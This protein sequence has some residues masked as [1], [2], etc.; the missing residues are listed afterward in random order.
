M[1][2]M[3]LLALSCVVPC[4]AMAQT[5]LFYVNEGVVNCPPDMPPQIDAENFV[6]NGSFNITFTNFTINS[7]LFDTANTLNFTNTGTMFAS[8][9]FEFVTA[10]V[11][12]GN[13]RMAANIHNEGSITCGTSSNLILSAGGP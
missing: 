11:N 1:K 3:F 7:Q 9:G 6:N 4:A 12:S 13:K 10:P 2:R 5:A 8:P